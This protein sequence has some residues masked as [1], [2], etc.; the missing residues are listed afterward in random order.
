MK[1]YLMMLAAAMMLLAMPTDSYAQFGKLKNAVKGAV[2]SNTTTTTQKK[3]G[4]D[5]FNRSDSEAEQRKKWAEMDAKKAAWEKEKAA[6]DAALAKSGTT[7][8]TSKKKELPTEP[9]AAAKAND[10]KATD[11]TIPE[12]FTK[13]IKALHAAYEALPAEYF[14]Q[15]YYEYAKFYFMD[16]PENQAYHEKA[17]NRVCQYRSQHTSGDCIKNSDYDYIKGNSGRMI[18]IGVP[19]AFAL[20]ARFIADPNSLAGTAAYVD[21]WTWIEAQRTSSVHYCKEVRDKDGDVIAYANSSG[22]DATKMT[23]AIEAMGIEPH[24]NLLLQV[25]D[26]N[27]AA[28]KTEKSALNKEIC[29]RRMEMAYEAIVRNHYTDGLTT[30]QIE[31]MSIRWKNVMR[32]IATFWDA[33]KA[34]GAKL[35]KQ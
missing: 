2:K 6:K 10:P 12:G 27:Y 22:E 3:N 8:A 7:S 31:D 19:T 32:K 13:S 28:F 9:S 4:A 33:S 16:T 30:E 11:E 26:Q 29:Y 14:H 25:F 18:G 5:E 34:E 35:L 1:K 23:N 21:L 17:Y 20:T 15:P 24:G